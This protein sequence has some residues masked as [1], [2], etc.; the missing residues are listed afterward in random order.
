MCHLD[1]ITNALLLVF[2]VYFYKNR[3]VFLHILSKA[4]LGNGLDTV[5]FRVYS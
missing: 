5:G 4:I 3:Y 1:N 2:V